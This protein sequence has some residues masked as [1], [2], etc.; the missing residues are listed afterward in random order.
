[1]KVVITLLAIFAIIGIASANGWLVINSDS[2][3]TTIQIDKSEIKRDAAATAESVKEAADEVGEELNDVGR[4][5]TNAVP[6]GTPERIETV[7]PSQAPN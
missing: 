4:S 6:D 2:N 1:M 3:Q 7:E 5:A